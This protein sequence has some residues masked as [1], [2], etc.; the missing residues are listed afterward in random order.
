MFSREYARDCCPVRS[1]ETLQITQ[2]MIGDVVYP[3]S[4][5]HRLYGTSDMMVLVTLLF[6][7]LENNNERSCAFFFFARPPSKF[8]REEYQ[9]ASR[10]SPECRR[11][12][13][14]AKKN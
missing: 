11:S 10:G 2:L 8:Q 6:A 3:R 1:G 12:K 7:F 5:A 14:N 13:Y 4:I 9:T